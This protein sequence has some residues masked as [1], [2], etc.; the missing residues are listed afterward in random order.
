MVEGESLAFFCA[1]VGDDDDVV[2]FVN[3]TDGGAGVG[4]HGTAD[5]GAGVDSDL[6]VFDEGWSEGQEVDDAVVNQFLGGDFGFFDDLEGA[7]G[8]DGEVAEVSIVSD[9]VAVDGAVADDVAGCVGT[10]VVAVDGEDGLITAGGLR[11]FGG[12]VGAIGVLS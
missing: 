1:A 11:G 8:V 4:G 3:D 5:F 12:D 2:V 10:V 9:G 6:A 7:I